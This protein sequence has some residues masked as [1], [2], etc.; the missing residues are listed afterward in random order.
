VIGAT[1]STS[2]YGSN[3]C[4]YSDSLV[5]TAQATRCA[6]MQHAI[7]QFTFAL[8]AAAISLVGYQVL[9]YW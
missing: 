4:F 9:T 6:P 7:T 2:T 8:I 1:L 3:A 5:L